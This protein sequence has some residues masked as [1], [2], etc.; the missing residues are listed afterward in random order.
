VQHQCLDL[1]SNTMAG[2]T[3]FISVMLGSGSSGGCIQ[4]SVTGL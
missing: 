4:L 2:L 1:I 3:P